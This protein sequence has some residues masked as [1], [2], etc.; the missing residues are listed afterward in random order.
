[1][2]LSRKPNAPLN[3]FVSRIW[4]AEGG[5]PVAG[6]SAR[7]LMLPAEQLHLVIRLEDQPLRIFSDAQDPR[8]HKVAAA[9]IAGIRT[10]PYVRDISRPV[11]CVGALLRPGAAAL[12]A[13]APAGDFA[14]AH[15][16]LEDIWGRGEVERFRACLA[17]AGPAQR[18]LDLFEALLTAR[19]PSFRHVDPRIARAL[20]GF[21]AARPV[22]AV[23]R[24]LG[25]S[26]RHF[27]TLFREA[28]GLAPRAYVRLR[29][30]GRVLERLGREPGVG[31]AALA[32]DEGYADQPHL[33]REFRGFSGLT[34]GEYRRRAPAAP[35]HVPL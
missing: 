35:R 26:H 1:M 33:V 20:A 18:R 4:A 16:P 10:A 17:V 12:L 15:L 6:G 27:T 11:A 24:E 29:R 13:G 2:H 19:L 7:E 25:T 8:G 21:A 31:W 5:P 34:P 30:F 32:A 28:V 23:A 9:V 22:G 3:A 14:G